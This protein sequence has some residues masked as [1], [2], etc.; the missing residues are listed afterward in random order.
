MQI[1]ERTLN[2]PSPDDDTVSQDDYPSANPGLDN[3]Q[4]YMP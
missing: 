4:T 3:F 1:V 2:E